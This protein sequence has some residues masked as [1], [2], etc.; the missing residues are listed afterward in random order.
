[1]EYD[2]PKKLGVDSSLNPFSSFPKGWVSSN[3][4]IHPV[5]KYVKWILCSLHTAHNINGPYKLSRI[6]STNFPSCSK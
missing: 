2:D 3:L 4:K 1:M 5:P 6:F